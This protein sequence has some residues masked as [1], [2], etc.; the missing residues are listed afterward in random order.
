MQCAL[1]IKS[2]KSAYIAGICF[3]MQSAFQQ[4]VKHQTIDF[5]FKCGYKKKQSICLQR[6]YRGTVI[7]NSVVLLI[8]PRI[9]HYLPGR[10]V[11]HLFIKPF[12]QNQQCN[13][14]KDL[15][16]PKMKRHKMN[17]HQLCNYLIHT[18][19]LQKRGFKKYKSLFVSIAYG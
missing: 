15:I 3:R 4:M 6:D 11:N 2:N 16:L 10:E 13:G 17:Y 18:S 19:S 14:I 7:I 12:I 8:S 1:H 9:P 5:I